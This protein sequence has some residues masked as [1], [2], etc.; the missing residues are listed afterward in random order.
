MG[1][2]PDSDA[3]GAL[4]PLR[5][6][7]TTASTVERRATRGIVWLL[8]CLRIPAQIETVRCGSQTG[9]GRLFHYRGPTLRAPREPVHHMSLGPFL[10]TS[11]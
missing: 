11:V 1:R 8:S 4:F 10:A 5:R 7:R 3:E 2:R 9:G 6:S